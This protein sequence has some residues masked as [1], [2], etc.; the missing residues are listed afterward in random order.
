MTT[1][2]LGRTRGHVGRAVLLG[3]AGTTGSAALAAVLS[4]LVADHWGG[5]ESQQVSE[6]L[7]LLATGAAAVISGWISVVLA[8]ATISLVH[9]GIA[10]GVPCPVRVARGAHPVTRRVAAGLLVLGSVGVAP[11]VAS[12][13]ATVGAP[14][15]AV[16]RWEPT[17]GVA[18]GVG[19]QQ[20]PADRMLPQPGWT[21][22][23][24][25]RPAAPST[26]VA[27]VS[28]PPSEP[29][30]R[31]VVHRGDTLWGLA[32][33]HLGDHATDRDVAEE[34]PRWYAANRDVIG[35]DPDLLRPGQQLVV[36]SS[37]GQR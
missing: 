23:L 28:T 12:A 32:A 13:S 15:S 31:V 30:D 4:A 5:W 14:V 27:L 36:P 22:T 17:P 29:L 35:D 8:A 3:A 18:A 7:G 24:T 1:R 16:E 37:G 26:D 20:D 11:S 33:Q 9:P 19:L 10:L 34:W 25:E 21:P 6:G 2:H